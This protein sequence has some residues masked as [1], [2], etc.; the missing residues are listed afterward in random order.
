MAFDKQLVYNIINRIPDYKEFL[1]IKELYDSS[2]K[3]AREHNDIAELIEVGPSRIDIPVEALIIH[4]G[5][6]KRILAFA[7]PHPNEPIGSLTLEALT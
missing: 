5:E 4:G 6:D 7:F 3:L 1:T 2:K